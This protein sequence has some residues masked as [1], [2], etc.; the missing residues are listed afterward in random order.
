MEAPVF[1]VPE[2]PTQ[3]YRSFQTMAEAELSMPRMGARGIASRIEIPWALTM[4]R[5][6]QRI[7]FCDTKKIQEA[8]CGGP[9]EEKENPN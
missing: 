9:K 1:R 5:R 2:I 7:L 6:I 4:R 3:A 8:N